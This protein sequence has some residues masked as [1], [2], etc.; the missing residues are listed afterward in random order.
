[1][2]WRGAPQ[3]LNPYRCDEGILLE[4]YGC[5]WSLVFFMVTYGL[6]FFGDFYWTEDLLKLGVQIGDF[7]S[8]QLS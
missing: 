7:T 5:F 6:D 8:Q 2:R 4:A 1:M 3:V